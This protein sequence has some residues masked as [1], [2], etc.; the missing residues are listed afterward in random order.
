MRSFKDLIIGILFLALPLTSLA[1]VGCI[2]SANIY[3]ING[4]N[5]PAEDEV[6]DS[7]S[8]L[9]KQILTFSTK[10]SAMR[11]VDYLYNDSGGVMLDVLH[12]LAA[13]KAVERNTAIAQ[14]FLAVG[15]AAF[16]LVS[17]LDDSDKRAVEQRV[18]G[19]INAA[20]PLETQQ[21]IVSFASRVFDDSMGNNVQAI[22]VPHSQGN[23]FANAVYDRI[24]LAHPANL[25]R[26]LGVVN[27]AN[28]AARAPNNSYL[29][30]AQD[31]VIN[32]LAAAQ[33]V[34]NGTLAP[35]PA[36]FDASAGALQVDS[37]GHG[38]NDVYMSQSL[39]TG[40]AASRSIAANVVQKIDV[41]LGQTST[42]IDTPSY[43]F[44][45]NGVKQPKPP[46]F[47]ADSSAVRVCFPGPVGG[48]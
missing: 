36:N 48:A 45:S 13:Q 37:T 31:R 10:R 40:A 21:L 2:E 15:F 41:M 4:V 43:Y 38:F 16:G 33:A 22:L 29:T 47:P 1:Q 9:R 34:A 32:V 18:A 20:L 24:R 39:P 28:P 25:A 7:A 14:T 30:A 8:L 12:E 27:I 3:Y 17:T 42:F 19:L 26:G 11:K 35:L 46:G 44:D 23:M 6:K 5:K